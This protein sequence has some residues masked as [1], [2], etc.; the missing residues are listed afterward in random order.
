LTALIE[1]LKNKHVDPHRTDDLILSGLEVLEDFNGK[2]FSDLSKKDQKFLKNQVLSCVQLKSLHDPDLKLM[3]FK[4]LNT[5]SVQLNAQELRNAAF[6]G[7]YNSELKKWAA[8]NDFRKLIGRNAPDLRMLDIELVLRFCAWVNRGW[9]SL[10]SKNLG[11]FLNN[12]M[13]IGAKTYKASDLNKLGQ[14]FKNAVQLSLSAFGSERAFRRYLPGSEDGADGV[15]ETRQINKA[16]YDVVMFEFTQYAKSQIFPHLE[17]IREELVDLM[18]TDAKFQDS[19]TAG[20]TDPKRVDYRFSTWHARMKSIINEDP[21]KRT[22]SRALKNKLFA[23]GRTCALCGQE[24]TDVDDAHVHHVE[25]YWRGG[26]TIPENAALT[27]RFCNMSEGGG[28]K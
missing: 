24:I 3:V 4:R 14:Q 20:T 22:F 11:K 9:T 28:V 13:D 10:T 21:Q 17:V 12:E 18:A 15:W 16:L 6:R 26:K 5:G 7:N 1:F 25:H 2:R 23:H 8:N 27:H 19:I